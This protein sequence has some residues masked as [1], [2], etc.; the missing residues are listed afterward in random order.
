MTQIFEHYLN[1]AL[2]LN[3]HH[4]DDVLN[5]FMHSYVTTTIDATDINFDDE[6]L[7]RRISAVFA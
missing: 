3:N 4:R 1:I 6:V 5:D 2:E 7:N